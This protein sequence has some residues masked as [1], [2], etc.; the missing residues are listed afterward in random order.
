[1]QQ[2]TDKHMLYKHREDKLNKTE[3]KLETPWKQHNS[4][5]ITRMQLNCKHGKPDT[6]KIHGDAESNKDK[7]RSKLHQQRSNTNNNTPSC[8]LGKLHS[9]EQ[10][11]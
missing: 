8:K 9:K 7:E 11:V 6:D 10:I 4:T 1:M 2:N 5:S 3:Q